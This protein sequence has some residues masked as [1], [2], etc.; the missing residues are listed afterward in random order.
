M[1]K[2]IS[3]IFDKILAYN[4]YQKLHFLPVLTIAVVQLWS[5]TFIEDYHLQP[6]YNHIKYLKIDINQSDKSTNVGM[7]R[8]NELHIRSYVLSDL[9]EL[10]LKY[11]RCTQNAAKY[12]TLKN[13]L[14]VFNAILKRTTRNAKIHYYN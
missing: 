9:D 7:K 8:T 4:F 14:R 3:A 1:T 5:I 2:R 12:Y 11:K 10:Y 6:L 13:N